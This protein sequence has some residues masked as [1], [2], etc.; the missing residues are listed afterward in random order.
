MRADGSAWALAAAAVV[1]LAAV[2]GGAFEAGWAAAAGGLMAL[3]AGAAVMRWRGAVRPDEAGFLALMAW[4]TVSAVVCAASPLAAKLT[5]GAWLGAWLLWTGLRRSSAVARTHLL[6]GLVAA[7]AVLAAGVIAEWWAFSVPRVGGLLENPNL[8]AALLAPLVAAVPAAVGRPPVRWLAT[9]VLLA[10]VVL[11][12]SRA[13]VAAAGL[14]LV[15]LLP[16]GAPRRTAI[17]LAALGVGALI[18]WRAALQPDP[19]AW[20]RPRI[21]KAVTRLAW[22]QPLVGLGPGGLADAAGRA[23]IPHD[24]LLG[25]F[26]RRPTSAES[27]V[28]GVLVQTGL[29]GLGLA[30]AAAVLWLR[31]FHRRGGLRAPPSVGVVAAVAVVA[32]LHDVLEL[33]VVLW[34]WAL[35]VGAV[36]PAVE[37]GGGPTSAGI[38]RAGRWA[39]ALVVAWVVLWALVQPAAA[40]WLWRTRAGALDVGRLARLEPWME[41]P[42]LSR[43]TELL[44]SPAWSWDE[45]G[46]ASYWSGRA[47]AVHRGRAEA[48]AWA[49]RVQARIASDLREPA[50]A[51]RARTCWQEACRLEPRLPWYLLE[52]ALLERS[53]G[54][55]DRAVELAARAVESEPRFV[56]GWMLLARLELERGRR[57]AA[58]DDLRRAE[59]A[60][61]AGRGRRLTAYERDLLEAPEWPLDALRGAVP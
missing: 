32:A 13:G 14:A 18:V 48:W 3:V 47:V 22:S 40:S 5:L 52:W 26:Q 34:W 7:G 36:D 60:L 17:A 23:R 4:A 28:V 31:R 6:R 56:R 10:A 58:A 45:A 16:E 42:M 46:E 9:G 44:A 19:L 41:Q 15:L 2:S 55:R 37:P 8:T 50:A 24:E 49:A 21:W 51:Q 35:V 29:P 11:T 39:A 54:A 25:R 27:T 61:A 43:A 57:G 30:A 38:G 1:T 12:G 59:T 53:L 33:T 20:Q